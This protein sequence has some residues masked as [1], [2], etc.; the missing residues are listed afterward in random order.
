M[1]KISRSADKRTV[2]RVGGI[3]YYGRGVCEVGFLK[4]KN[5][6]DDRITKVD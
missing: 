1:L 3:A 6:K 4:A 2:V 5:T